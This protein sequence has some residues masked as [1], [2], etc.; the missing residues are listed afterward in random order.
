[1]AES[2]FAQGFLDYLQNEKRSSKQTV[3]CYKAD[4]RQFCE[5][6][7]SRE[8]D[9][10]EEDLNGN[11][12]NQAESG[13]VAILTKTSIEQK[14][15]LVKPETIRSYLRS[16]ENDNYDKSTMCRKLVS[17]RSFYKY[18]RRQGTID[19]NPA[20]VVH[21]PKCEKRAPKILSHEEVIRLLDTPCLD[22]WI[23]ARDRA[24][25]ETFYST[26]I[27]V[28]EL[29]ALN[30]EDVDYLGESIRVRSRGA[31]ERTVPIGL[32]A[33][34]S[35]QRY[36]EMRNNR[37]ENDSSFDTTVLFSNKHGK[38]LGIR[39][40]RRKMDKYLQ[41]AGLDIESSPHTLRH[42]FAAHMLETGMDVSR[43]QQLLGHQSSSIT[44]VYIDFV[45][46]KAAAN[47]ENAVSSGV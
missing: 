27:R 6:L 40:I 4:L 2:E 9:E 32:S 45:A 26:G 5:F 42:S 23:G 21:S 1:M 33:L 8:I 19:N 44:Q 35:I 14:L 7:A 18:L 36:I 38:R 41:K 17:L 34:R 20:M 39:S 3:K 28:G 29:V 16:L 24:I 37:S 31:K 25:F 12:R 13:G 47:D 15:L 10:V 43:L 46:N 22:N 11:Y 30:M